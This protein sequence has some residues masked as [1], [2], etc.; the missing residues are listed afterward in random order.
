[1]VRLLIPFL[2]IALF[3]VTVDGRE[4][5]RN[6]QRIQ[7]NQQLQQGNTQESRH[8]YNEPGV[9]EVHAVA[10][11]EDCRSMLRQ[12]KLQ[13]RNIKLKKILKGRGTLPYNCIFEGEDA[14]TGV[15]DEKRY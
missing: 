15:F 4:I 9:Q 3:P 6:W 12:F 14:Q 11:E 13:G 5:I 1:M 7:Q 2:L 10:S 8:E